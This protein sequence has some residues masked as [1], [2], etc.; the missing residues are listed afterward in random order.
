MIKQKNIEEIKNMIK[1]N[2][3]L[4]EKLKE[5]CQEIE[6]LNYKIK[7]FERGEYNGNN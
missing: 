6:E 7:I 4:R 3:R 5:K 2:H 1:E